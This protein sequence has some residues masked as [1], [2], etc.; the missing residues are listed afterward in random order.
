M[1][2]VDRGWD[3]LILLTAA[4]AIGAYVAAA[5][6]RR[7]CDAARLRSASNQLIAHLLEFQLFGD[8]PAL[9]LKAQR[10]L[11]AANGR[12]LRTVAGPSLAAG[13]PLAILYICCDAMF[14]RAPIPAKQPTVLTVHYRSGTPGAARILSLPM[15]VHADAGPVHVPSS[16]QVCWR[17]RSDRDASGT[18]V[19]DVDGERI[20]KT[21]SFGSSLHWTSQRRSGMSF[22]L[23]PQELPLLGSN[24]RS[25]SVQYPAATVFGWPWQLWFTG[26]CLVGSLFALALP[27][28]RRRARLRPGG[29]LVSPCVLDA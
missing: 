18:V 10:E 29:S 12:L 14:G 13:I 24:A 1:S 11:L 17:L 6:F 27:R 23:H 16:R 5:L 8:D 7:W 15:S 26:G 2:P 4:G 28:S 21:V 20:S 19:L 9:V 25:I 22:L 3:A